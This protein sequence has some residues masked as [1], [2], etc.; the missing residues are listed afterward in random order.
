RHPDPGGRA[1]RTPRYGPSEMKSRTLLPS[2][3]SWTTLRTWYTYRNPVT[4]TA[5]PSTRPATFHH[6]ENATTTTSSPRTSTTIP[7]LIPGLPGPA[8][9]SMTNL[10]GIVYAVRAAPSSRV[11]VPQFTQL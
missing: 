3:A 7:R 5:T 4:I 2:L 11:S 10:A 8:A 6:G 1:R 9:E